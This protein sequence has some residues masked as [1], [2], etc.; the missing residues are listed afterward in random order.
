MLTS[1]YTIF[2]KG[3]YL[4]GARESTSSLTLRT[5]KQQSPATDQA[6]VIE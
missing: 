6:V 2:G 5:V 4:N 3:V 1:Y